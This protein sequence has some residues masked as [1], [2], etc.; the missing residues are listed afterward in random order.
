MVLDGLGRK[1]DAIKDYS[2]ALIY[3]TDLT[4][5]IL[6]NRAVLFMETEKFREAISDLDYLI[7]EDGNNF[8]YYYNRAFAK[9]KLNDIEGAIADYRKVLQLNPGDKET[10]QQ[11]QI[12]IDS[13]GR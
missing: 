5:E 2:V 6:S 1:E 10:A 4:I 11:L 7:S 8:M 12:L 9:L 13:Q 3:Q